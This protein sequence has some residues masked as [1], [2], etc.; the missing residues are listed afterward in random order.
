MPEPPAHEPKPVV[1]PVVSIER[2]PSRAGRV[3]ARAFLVH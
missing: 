3:L 1:S 2:P